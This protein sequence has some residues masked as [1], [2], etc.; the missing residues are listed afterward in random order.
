MKIKGIRLPEDISET[1]RDF[2][3][4]IIE[5]LEERG[6]LDKLDGFS[7][8]S[9]AGNIDK[10]L[11]CED[12]WNG[13]ITSKTARDTSQINPV[14]TYQKQLQG[15]IGVQLKEM[16]LTLGSRNKIKGAETD[17]ETPLSRAL[18]AIN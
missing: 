5:T 12:E 13:S 14:L 15:V 4:E 8:Y 7:L 1:A 17:E 11:A 3:A 16:G 6:R 10:Y 2:M 18:G 9:L